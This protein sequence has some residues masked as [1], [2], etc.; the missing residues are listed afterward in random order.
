MIRLPW[1]WKYHYLLNCF[2]IKMSLVTDLVVWLSDKAYSRAR[3]IFSHERKFITSQ[4]VPKRKW[5]RNLKH[6]RCDPQQHEGDKTLC[7]CKPPSL[8]T[9]QDNWLE[10]LPN[11]DILQCD[12]HNISEKKVIDGCS[13]DYHPGRVKNAMLMDVILSAEV[14]Q[15]KVWRNIV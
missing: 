11:N 12:C 4:H 1:I 15:S 10:K 8:D 13:S 6:G 14:K 2:C 5:I 9:L 7:S 3:K